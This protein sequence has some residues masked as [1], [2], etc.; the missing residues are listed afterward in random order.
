MKTISTVP[1]HREMQGSKHKYKMSYN[2]RNTVLLSDIHRKKSGSQVY[3][4]TN[5]SG[6]GQLELC[7]VIIISNSMIRNP[8]TLTHRQNNIQY[9]IASYL[10]NNYK[11]GIKLESRTNNKLFQIHNC[12]CYPPVGLCDYGMLSTQYSSW[13]P[14]FLLHHSAIDRVFAM[15]KAL[16]DI[17]GVSDWTESRVVGQY[18]KVYLE[19]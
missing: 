14:T 7:Y 5:T 16:E 12:Y 1:Q 18:V 9:T 2:Q 4:C 11:L 8:Q 6:K 13:S 3:S 10:R 15:K 17:K 19:F